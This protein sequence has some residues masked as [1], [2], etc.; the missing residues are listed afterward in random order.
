MT[1]PNLKK[2][3]TIT[4]RTARVCRYGFAGLTAV[5]ATCSGGSGQGFEDQQHLLRQCGWH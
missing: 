3:T 1:A 2:P 5:L 4:G